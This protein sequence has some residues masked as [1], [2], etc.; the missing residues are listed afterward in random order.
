MGS[1]NQMIINPG[2][3]SGFALDGAIRAM[4]SGQKPENIAFLPRFELVSNCLITSVK[5][6]ACPGGETVCLGLGHRNLTVD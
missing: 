4:N 3:G 5:R 2:T 6:E 1:V